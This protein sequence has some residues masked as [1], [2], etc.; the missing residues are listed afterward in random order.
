MRFQDKESHQI[1]LEPEGR[2]VP[3]LYVQVHQHITFFFLNIGY[4]LDGKGCVW[5]GCAPVSGCDVCITVCVCA[6]LLESYGLLRG[7]MGSTSVSG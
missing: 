5:L 7:S 2:N 3:E 6:W 1:F 4:C